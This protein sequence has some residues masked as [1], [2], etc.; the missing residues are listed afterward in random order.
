MK[1]FLTFKKSVGW[2]LYFMMSLIP[3]LYYFY[4]KVVIL[5]ELRKEINIFNTK[6]NSAYLHRLTELKMIKLICCI[7]SIIYTF[8]FINVFF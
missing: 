2:R 4:T 1:H 7:F 3:F 8:I 6:K 5:F